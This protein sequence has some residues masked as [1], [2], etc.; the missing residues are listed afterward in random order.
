MDTNLHHIV[1]GPPSRSSKVLFS[2]LGTGDFASLS[3]MQT[4]QGQCREPLAGAVM[5]K[6]K[7]KGNLDMM[8]MDLS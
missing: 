6:L 8:F 5:Y 1:S 7:R 3:D 4:R 2:L